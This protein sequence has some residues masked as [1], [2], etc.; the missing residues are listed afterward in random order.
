MSQKLVGRFHFCNNVG[1]V[2]QFLQ[3]FYNQIQKGSAEEAEIR[4]ITSP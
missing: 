3:F 2:D 1:K 4:T